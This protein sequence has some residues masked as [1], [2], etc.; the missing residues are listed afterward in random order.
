MIKNNKIEK[1]DCLDNY[2]LRI[3]NYEWWLRIGICIVLLFV[4]VDCQSGKKSLNDDFR[5][6]MKEAERES[7]LID[8]S[9]ISNLAKDYVIRG[10]NLEQMNRYA[11]AILSF[12]EA[13]KY[14]SSTVIFGAIA[15][16]FV[17]LGLY[18]EAIDYALEAL[19]EDSVYVPAMETLY[20]VYSYRL[21]LDDAIRVYRQIVE[22]E[23]T[24]YRKLT[25]GRLYELKDKDKA[26]GIYEE[27]LG[28]GENEEVL[29]RLGELFKEKKDYTKFMNVFEKLNRDY[30]VS[31][32]ILNSLIEAYFLNKKYVGAYELLD[33]GDSTEIDD[34]LANSYINFGDLLLQDSSSE[35]KSYIPG[36]LGRVEKHFHYNWRIHFLGAML[37]DKIND[38][39]RTE[40]FIDNVLNYA[41]TAQ[42]VPI[43]AGLF[44][45][46]KK[47]Y[48]KSLEIFKKY[49]EIY[50]EN[51]NFPFFQASVYLEMDSNSKAI[52]PL[53]KALEI[54]KNNVMV[55]G[56]LGL[57]YDR[58]GD[59]KSCDS[60]YEK[61]LSLNPEDALLN[62]NYAYSLSERGIELDRA[63]KMSELSLTADSNN[64][65]YLDTY[66]WIKF[67]QGKYDESLV[68]IEKAI[69]TGKPSG[70][71]YE[72]LGDIYI[73]LNKKQD[74][75][76]AYEKSL[77][78]NPGNDD[79][80][81]KLSESK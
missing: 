81:K 11:E 69:D 12:Q 71:V 30:G 7:N 16:N 68:Y 47:K 60:I 9:N 15:N 63:L 49:G 54:D 2:E 41:D 29:R 46:N 36:Y 62:N 73:K 74:A 50:P 6:L 52:V 65:S 59:Y 33:K 23:P 27:L 72:H 61:A 66:G 55:L 76:K 48:D 37:S 32:A 51:Y 58:L 24:Y 17:K 70:E 45:L 1:I 21:R 3:T 10:S 35:A 75:V 64:S 43:Q 22:L 57:A 77:D 20:E 13:L 28:E 44:Y 78:L 39:L 18:S 80:K 25:L 4:L 31:P 19:K 34:E 14:D 79:V 56:Q 38:S 5:T 67:K 42:D 40:K 8:T 53:L 26:I